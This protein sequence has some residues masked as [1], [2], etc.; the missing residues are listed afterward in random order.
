MKVS[1]AMSLFE[2]LTIFFKHRR[3]IVLIFVT[4]VG[5]VTAV[6]FLQRP[7][8]EAKSSLLVKMLKDDTPRPGMTVENNNLSLTLSQDE[9]INTEVLI[10]TGQELAEKVINTVRI[11]NLYPDLANEKNREKSKMTMFK[12]VKM[13]QKSL[14]VIGVRKS[15]VIN[16]SFQHHNPEVAARVVNLLDEYF[17]DKHLLLHSDPQSSFISS[18]LASFEAKLKESEGELQAY[19]Q[20]NNAFSLD[21]QRALLLKQRTDFDS[22]YKMTIDNVGEQKKRIVALKG[23]I[24]FLSN[25]NNRYTHTDRD[26]IIIDAKSRLLELKLKEQELRRKYTDNNRLVVDAKNEVNLVDKFLK[27]QEEGIAGKVKTGNP[28]YQ[29]VEMDLYRAQA[30]LNSQAAKAEALKEQIKQLEKQIT[31]LDMSESKIQRL[32]RE[33]AI[34]EKNYKTYADRHEEARISDAMNQHK[35]SNISVIQ[36]AEIPAKPIKPK[37][38][39]NLVLGVVFGIIAGFGW[40]YVLENISQTFSD[41]ESVERYLGLPVLLTVSSKEV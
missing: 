31:A 36:P 2:T 27:E 28:V 24:N 33:V 5:I 3:K 11:E 1:E 26:K 34:N 9:L 29:S 14:K 16:V 30:D 40:A 25:N 22:A 35:L 15:N 18:Q 8:Y 19:Q 17:N 32:K 20:G 38:K 21:E 6:T 13:F 7:V 39:L 23:Q 10:L 41:P 37:K 4:V 12:A